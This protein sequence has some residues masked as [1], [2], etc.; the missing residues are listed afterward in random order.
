MNVISEKRNPCE[1]L[2]CGPGEDCVVNQI[3][4]I[5][6]AQCVCPTQ[7]PNYGDS[8]ESSPVCSSHGVDYQSSCHLRHHACE[9]K[10]NITVKFYGRCGKQSTVMS[11]DLSCFQIPATATSAQTVRLVNWELIE[12]P[13]ADAVSSARWT[14]HTSAEPMGRLTW[15]SAFWN[16][17]HAK[18]R[19]KSTFGSEETV[20]KWAV[21][22]RKWNADSGEVVWSSRIE[23]R[24]ASVRGSV[25]IQWDPCVRR[26]ERRSITSARWRRRAARWRWT[27]EW[28]IKEPVELESVP[29]SMPVRNRKFV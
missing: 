20:T 25:R 27:S 9:S 16:S 15:T 1:D 10:T 5:L 3:N 29:P 2:R 8:V 18:N 21:R 12:N 4:G 14:V 7:C 13:S 6:L 26:T 22:V 24:S 19:E 23:R 11:T 17:L 28:S